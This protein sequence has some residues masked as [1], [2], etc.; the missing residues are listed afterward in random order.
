M[1]LSRF[2]LTTL[3]AL[4]PGVAV[5]TWLFGPGVIL[6]VLLGGLVALGTEAVMLKIRQRPFT[7]V[8]N[9]SA[10]LT[11]VLLGLCVPPLTPYIVLITGVVF[12]LVFGK[13]VYGGTGNNVFN[14]AMVGFAVMILSFPAAMSFWPAP[15]DAGFNLS[16]VTLKADWNQTLD[17][18]GVTAAT[19]LDAYKF[20][21]AQTNIEFFGEDRTATTNSRSAWLWISVSYLLG[22]LFL[23]SRKIIPWQTPVSFLGTM[24]VLSILFYDGGSSAS[25]GSPA[26]HLLAGAAMMAAFFILTDPVT[27]PGDPRGLWVFGV[28]VGVITFVIRSYG[29]YPEGVAFAVLLMNAASPAIDHY[30]ASSD[31]RK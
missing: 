5:S 16:A 6:N 31:K 30:F 14:P 28:G 19:P 2:M 21:E 17:Y 15:G 1:G 20:R 29:A 24:S 3:A 23:I 10:A 13:Q 22:G 9:G 7:E 8:R 11:G 4:I 25:L 18:D 12:G 26:F 27:C